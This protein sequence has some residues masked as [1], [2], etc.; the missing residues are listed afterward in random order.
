MHESKV[1][2]LLMRWCME[3]KNHELV[4]PNLRSV[5]RWEADL[6]SATRAWLVHEFEIKLTHADFRA[7]FD[8]KFKHVSLRMTHEHS[9]VPYRCPNYFW[10]VTYGFEI[11]EDELPDYAGWMH[12]EDKDASR[13]PHI[14]FG[15]KERKNAPRL[16]MEKLSEKHRLRIAR[17]LSYKLKNAYYGHW[18][19]ENGWK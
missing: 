3:T 6:L 8:K 16:H 18:V 4:I 2:A 9:G 5:Y 15:I 10:Y 7:D 12:I 11:D 13:W 17:W 1:Q 19:L 14:K